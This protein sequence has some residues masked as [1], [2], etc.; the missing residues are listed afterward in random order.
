VVVD[1]LTPELLLRHTKA[2]PRYTSYPTVPSWDDSV[3]DAEVSVAMEQAPGP[4]CETPDLAAQL[5]SKLSRWCSAIDGGL[6]VT[7]RGVPLTREDQLGRSVINDL[8]CDFEV[9]NVAMVFD[10]S[11][12]RRRTSAGPRFSQTV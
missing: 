5:V 7:E 2:G 11:L 10:P 1:G 9:R 8:T 6:P 3:T 12:R 4:S